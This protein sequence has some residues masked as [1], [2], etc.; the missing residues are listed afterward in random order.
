M[1]QRRHPRIPLT[2]LILNL[3]LTPVRADAPFID[4]ADD[5]ANFGA[6]DNILF[7]T[8]PQKIAGF[9]NMPQLTPTRSIAASQDPY[10]LPYKLADLSGLA[11]GFKDR[12][13]TLDDYMRRH[14][15][16]GLLVIKDGFVVYERYEL[17][18]TAE[19]RWMSWSV[20]KSVTSL[21]LGA[22]IRDGY[23]K[24]V[25]EKVSDYLPRLKDSSYDEVTI[26]AL[27][28]MSSG[29][30]WNEDYADPESDIN[31]INWDTLSVYEAL[32]HK[33]RVAPPGAV[34]SYNTAETNLVGTLLRAAIGNNLSAYLEEKIWQPFGMEFSASWNLTEVG[35]GEFGGSSLNA[36]LRDYGRIGLFVLRNGEL[37]DGTA[38]LAEGWIA[39]STT[40]STGLAAY[41]YLWWL[42][43]GGVFAAS[44]IFG[45]AIHIDPEHKL[46]IAQ[47]SAREA[48]NAPADWALQAAFFAALTAEL[49]Q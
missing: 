9:R 22:A 16:A 4:P 3:L 1:P 24:S 18:N 21:L 10:P 46:V 32:R 26:R 15:V 20:A 31:T 39:E 2:L 40:A 23:I 36:T 43:G 11:F 30:A 38:V 13:L 35:G 7:W 41:G 29:V 37:R 14:N 8:V 12:E 34:F 45:Q 6:I 42:R 44:G 49:T 25:G 19:S 33:P 48:A 28:Q 17:G 47:H 5:A 27:L